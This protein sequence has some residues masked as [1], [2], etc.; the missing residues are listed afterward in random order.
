MIKEKLSLKQQI[1]SLEQNFLN[2]IKEKESLLQ[3]FIVFKNES[4]EKESKYMDKKNDLEKKIKELDNIVYK[5]DQSAQTVH[6]LIKPQVFYDNAH[7]QAL[8]Y[9]NLFY[10]K[11]AQRIKPTLY[12]GS[13]ISSQHADSPVI[14]DEETLILEELNRLSKDFGKRF[15]PQQELSDE[16]AFWLQTSHPNTDQSALL[17]IQIEVPKELPKTLKDI[18]N[19]FDK[20]LLNEVTEVQTVFNQMK[21]DVQR[22]FVDKQCYEIHKKELFLENDRLLQKIMS[23][24]VMLCVMNSIVVFDDVNV[25]MQSSESFVMCVDLDAELLNKQNAYND[26]LKSYSQLEKHCISLELTMQ[27]NQEIFQKDSLSNNQNALEILE[28]FENN[29][30]KAQLQA[31]DTI[32]CKLKEHIKSMREND[33]EEKVKH[34]MDEIETI[35][36][37]LEHRKETVE[38]VAQIPIATTI[39]PGMFKIDLEPLA[40]RKSQYH[41]IWKPKGKVFTEVGHKWKPTGRLFTIV[42]NSCPLTR[43]TPKKI[44]HLKK[45]TSIS[46]ETSKP[47]IKVYSMRP[48]QVKSVGS[49]KKA[50]TVVQI[51]L[52]YLDS[53]C[54]KHMTRNRSELM[55]FVGKFLGTVRFENNQVAKI[56]GYG[57]YQLGNNLDG[58]NLLSGSSDTNLY[59]IS[60]DDMLKTSSICLLSKDSKT[61]SW[62]W[63]RRLSHLNFGT[64]NKLAKDGLA[65]G[66]LKLKFKKYHLCSTCALGKSKKSSHK[67]KAEDTDQEKLYLLHMDLCSS[68][69]VESI[70]GKKYILV[71][72]DDY[73]R[74]TWVRFLR[75]KDEA[76]D[77]IIKCIKNIQVRL[78]AIVRNVRIDN[79]TE[80][81][82]Q[83]LRDFY[84]NVSISHQTSIARTPQQNSIVERQNRTLMEAA[85][86]MLIFLKAPLFLWA[87]AINTPCYTQNRSLIRL[88]YNKTPYE[89]MHEKKLDLS[90]LH[91]FGSLYYPTN[92]SE[93]LG[94]LHAK[95]DIGILL[96]TRSQRKLS[97]SITGEPRKLWKLFM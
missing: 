57:D 33:K 3:T 32:I 37:E 19:V 49:S 51:V 54:S 2:Q 47:E 93:D 43:I 73:S 66:I 68:M 20:D 44:V 84:E 88:R 34:E 39:A 18:F 97:E 24:D 86:T 70:N 4:K 67:P 12:D 31:K 17:P 15:V 13:V 92:D 45:T 21:A 94:K 81:V 25:E 28:Y 59:T 56:M 83:T 76:P 42:G 35:N 77:A 64:L 10:L 72:V 90:F 41:N 46:V 61:K 5:V 9:Q 80:F 48:K 60:L 14:D 55:N 58:V 74:F 23:Q 29:D 85:R 52:W 7:K 8:G 26:L 50:K 71:I 96:V 36:I 16:Q 89:L 22:Y 91:V 53:G 62:L 82:N 95:A 30:L 38:N 78:N 40:P 79:G 1:N 11:K 63:H 75:S 65:R 69:R 27:L 87:E 6:M